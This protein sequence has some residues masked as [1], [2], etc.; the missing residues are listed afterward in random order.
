MSKDEYDDLIRFV[1]QEKHRRM[2]T[3]FLEESD[4]RWARFWSAGDDE[5]VEGVF[6][7]WYSRLPMPY[8]PWVENR[9]YN[10]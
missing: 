5:D 8:I 10:I 9:R 1:S 7:N 6:V 4:Y 2:A 3:V